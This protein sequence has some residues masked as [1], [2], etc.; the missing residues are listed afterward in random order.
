M[1]ARAFRLLLLFSCILAAVYGCSGDEGESSG[2][3][4]G[5]AGSAGASTGG[6]SAGGS[7][8]GGSGGLDFDASIGMLTI[9]PP[10]ATITITDKGIAASEQFSAKLS[11]GQTVTPTWVLSNYTLGTIDSQG[12]Y[13]STGI[14]AGVVQVKATYQALD[15]TAQL[16]VKVDIREDVKA[17]PMDPGPDPSNK[18]GLDAPGSDPAVKLLYPYNDTMF[19]RG[20]R[21]PI[22]QFAPSATPPTDAKL[23]LKSTHFSWSGY[24]KIANPARPQITPPQDVWDAA[25][26]SASGQTIDVEVAV[27]AGGKGFGPAKSKLNAAQGRLK[28][29]VYYMT[30]ESPN[31]LYSVRPGGD[32]PANRIAAGCVVCHAVSANGKR[33]ATGAEGGAATSGWYDINQNYDITQRS[34]SPPGLGGDTRGLSMAAFTPDGKYVTRS[35]NNF[36]GGVNLKAWKINDAAGTL[37]EATVVGMGAMVS[38]YVPAFSPDGK[39]YVFVTGDSTGQ[40]GTPRR[41][42]TVM[43]VAI[44]DA[45]GPNGTLTFSNATV[46]LD[47]GMSG[48]GCKY[49]TFLPDSNELIV[50]E[51]DLSASHGGMLATHTAGAGYGSGKGRLFMVRT[52]GSE[53]IELK[54]LNTGNVPTDELRNYEPFALPEAAAGYHWVV[55]TSIREYGNIMMGAETRKRLW[56]AAIKIGGT[57][58]ADPSFPAFYLPNQSD[59][60][61][62]RG[63]W[64]LEPCEPEEKTCQTD[65][66]CCRG[67]CK[68]VD[69]TDPQSEKKC[70]PEEEKCVPFGGACTETKDCC[71]HETAGIQCI[72]GK[73]GTKVQ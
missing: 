17:T 11:N 61:N 35:Q 60:K 53:H 32:Q 29:A 62:E 41:S 2:G 36:W 28:G 23:T 71:D 51:G 5:T 22:F 30:Y 68:P 12:L 25:L 31:G 58:G 72:E 48:E 55:F 52:A 44:N 24:G 21:A 56:V 63:Y 46:P 26:I 3:G 73:C 20:L 43:D 67:L 37:D 70:T 33:L 10:T 1:A 50:Q 47:N 69:P 9:D 40:P 64:A 16:T 27:A 34:G 15:A 18:P 39:K 65:D 19:P 13:T 57:P 14:V 4:F 49:P 59:T 7:S 45:M 66:D 6:S 54:R 42:L 38:A 8:A